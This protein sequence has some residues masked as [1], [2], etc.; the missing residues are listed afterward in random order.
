MIRSIGPSGEKFLADLARIQAAR[1]RAQRAI[2]SGLK[3]ASPSDQP[4]QVGDIL[5]LCADIGRNSQI[6][7][8]LN[9]MKSE[10]DTAESLLQTAVR[11]VEHARALASQ[12][13]GTIAT[14]ENRRVLADE[15]QGL[16]EQLVSISRTTVEGRHIFS[17]DRDQS[18]QYE[19]DPA[20]PTGVSRLFRTYAS[21]RIEHPNG[22]SFLAIGTAEELFDAR[23]PDD[24][25]S[26]GNVFAALN[27]LRV[28]LENDDGVGI[29]ASLLSLRAAGDDL[30]SKL[31]ACGNL[32]SK[33][34]EA[35]NYGHKLGLQLNQ[36]LSSKRD[37][38]L[39]AA[40][41]ELQ[42]SSTHEEAALRSRASLPSSSL[43]DFLG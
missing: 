28:A 30:N 21:R 17:G 24:T 13:A 23:N 6:L 3:V 26:A 15:A 31:S 7:T 33:I 41:I 4:G 25:L 12:G 40:I 20:S 11:I 19:L 22:T 37:A 1:E 9:R 36:E 8:N 27:A 34:A 39:T 42:R 38:D 35:I 16:L 2:S 32:Q 14:P 5:Q 10:V 29:D 43:F 18:P